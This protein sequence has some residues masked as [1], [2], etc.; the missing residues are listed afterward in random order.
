MSQKQRALFALVALSILLLCTT[1]WADSNPAEI[2][3]IPEQPS[4]NSPGRDD[5]LSNAGVR[6]NKALLEIFTATN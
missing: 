5:F 2:R 4:Y 6:R 1:L 3:C